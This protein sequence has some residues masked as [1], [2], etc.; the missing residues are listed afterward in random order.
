MKKNIDVSHMRFHVGVQVGGN[1]MTS[2]DRE[3]HKA[4]M[5]LMPMGV[6]VLIEAQGTKQVKE[7]IVPYSNI[8]YLEMVPEQA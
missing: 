8:H 4:E 3:K 5:E 1:V 6:H 2:M 7:L